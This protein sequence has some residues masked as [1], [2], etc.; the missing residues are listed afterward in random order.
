MPQTISECK[1]KK[2]HWCA[3]IR[4]SRIAGRRS[5]RFSSS[6]K[7]DKPRS[8]CTSRKS[9]L[10]TRLHS[11]TSSELGRAVHSVHQASHKDLSCARDFDSPLPLTV[12]KQIGLQ[13]PSCIVCNSADVAMH[14]MCIRINTIRNGHGS[15]TLLRDNF[16]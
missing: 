16:R 1:Q 8:E 11:S 5:S 2:A 14:T 13:F 12:C 3:N 9:R 4:H 15:H 10:D 6:F 7:R